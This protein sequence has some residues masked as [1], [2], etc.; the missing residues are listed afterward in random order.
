MG[1]TVSSA[2]SVAE[3]RTAR[4]RRD[5]VDGLRR[6]R[7][8]PRP[9]RRAAPAVVPAPRRSDGAEHHRGQRRTRGADGRGSTSTSGGGTGGCGPASAA[10]DRPAASAQEAATAAARPSGWPP[11]SRPPSTPNARLSCR[12]PAP[13]VRDAP[14]VRPGPTGRLRFG[15]VCTRGGSCSQTA[16]SRGGPGRHAAALL[17]LPRPHLVDGDAH[18]RALRR[19]GHVQLD[20]RH[21]RGRL[22]DDRLSRIQ[23][24]APRAR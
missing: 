9:G 11:T 10:A 14:A 21:G 3:S 20:G 6:D 16:P 1:L 7:R 15:G 12:A 24:A 5:R 8:R 19:R 2:R 17:R 22:T 23:L 18:R 4:Q 13:G